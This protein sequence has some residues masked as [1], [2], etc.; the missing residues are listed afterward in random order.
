MAVSERKLITFHFG[1]FKVM[2]LAWQA[3]DLAVGDGDHLGPGAAG[4]LGDLDTS[5]AN[6]G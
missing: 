2:S 3:G 5:R 1:H 4:A 6:R